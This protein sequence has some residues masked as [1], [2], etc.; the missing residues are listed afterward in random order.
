MLCKKC[1][2][3]LG[4]VNVSTYNNVC[5]RKY[6]CKHCGEKYFTE[7]RECTRYVYSRYTSFKNEL[8]EKEDYGN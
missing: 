4:V 7:E 3:R 1:G 2:E 8:K 6:K 5:V